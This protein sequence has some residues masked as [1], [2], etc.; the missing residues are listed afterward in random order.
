MDD[1]LQ[2]QLGHILTRTAGTGCIEDHLPE[3]IGKNEID[4][5]KRLQ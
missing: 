1:H 2:V 4:I 3:R 5:L